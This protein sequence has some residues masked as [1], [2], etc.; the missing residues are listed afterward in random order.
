[1]HFVQ[2]LIKFFNLKSIQSS[3]LFDFQPRKHTLRKVNREIWISIVKYEYQSQ[4]YIF[5]YGMGCMN[6]IV[7]FDIDL[8]WYMW[9]SEVGNLIQLN[10]WTQSGDGD[11]SGKRE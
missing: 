6:E 10:L 3:R 2:I 9:V 7:D 8:N 1:M 4:H 5:G 11:V